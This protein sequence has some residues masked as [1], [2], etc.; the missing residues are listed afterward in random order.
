[1]ITNFDSF[2]FL[3]PIFFFFL[4]IRQP[5]RSTL[6]PYTT[7]FRST[8]PP[9]L[10]RGNPRHEPRRQ[11]HQPFQDARRRRQARAA[12]A[13]RGGLARHPR[14]DAGL[15]PAGG[16]HSHARRAAGL[17]GEAWQVRVLHRARGRGAALRPH[18]LRLA[19]RRGVHGALRGHRRRRLRRADGGA[20]RHP[21]E[22]AGPRARER[23]GH[24]VP[25]RHPDVL[26]H[27]VQD[28]RRH[29]RAPAR[30]PRRVPGRAH[31]DGEQGRVRPQGPVGPR[32]HDPQHRARRRGHPAAEDRDRHP[33]GL[34]VFRPRAVRPSRRRSA[35]EP[36][37]AIRRRD[38]RGAARRVRGLAR[39]QADRRQDDHERG[40]PG[41]P[42]PRAGLRR[43]RQDAG[44]QVRHADLPLHGSV[45]A[46]QLRQHPPEA[47]ARE[48]AVS[49]RAAAGAWA[50][51]AGDGASATRPYA[52]AAGAVAVAGV[53]TAILWPL[54]QPVGTPL[55][56]AAVAVSS[57]HGGL[58]PGL[59]A[60][61]LAALVADW[62][63]V[64]PFYE[65]NAGT[66]VRV[67]AFVM[68]ALLTASLYERA[69]R[70]QREA[71]ALARAREWL[72]RD[73]QAA[74]AAAETAS[75]AKD[76]FLATLSHE[77]RTPLNALVG[78]TWW[79][80]R[81][82]LP[83]ERRARALETLDR[84]AKA[85]AQLIEDLL[86]VSRIITGK[87]RLSVRT[88]DL[89]AVV[90]A[91]IAAVL[92]AAT[93]KSLELRVSVMTVGPMRGDP[94]RLQ[95]VVWNLLSNAI[96]FTPE[97]GTVT[98]RVLRDAEAATIVV[99]DSG[100]GIDPDV[101]PQIFER[102]MQGGGGRRSGGLGLGLSIARHIVELH[103]GTIQAASEGAGRGAAFTVTLPLAAFG[104]EA[105][106]AAAP[107]AEQPLARLDGLRVL[108]VDDD[109]AARE[110]C[111]L[112]LGSAGAVTTT[113]GSA[114]EAMA[115]LGREEPDVLVSD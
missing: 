56:F 75:R 102:F 32:R 53:Y 77:L 48:V 105:A 45:A 41:R 20:R 111:A 29:H 91:A 96:K 109:P 67:A 65:L 30:R 24:A 14:G 28:A 115:A 86:E 16:R 44:R 27:R 110:W 40:V 42:R 70:A 82:D 107:A 94:D 31:E 13:G 43:A 76:E 22:R 113:V 98:V 68:V 63:F 89:P 78:W 4:M 5:P 49:M 62:F 69:R 51:G 59:L 47:G 38:L 60:T 55:F 81:G 52:V 84:N 114:A 103:G 79:L 58:G 25:D 73:E 15:P 37:G 61:A 39:Q 72:L 17:V 26:R 46:V 106:V 11:A 101:L 10:D 19:A 83:P 1:M 23:G 93:A 57:W 71:E 9:E 90:D 2:V 3:P 88:L 74:R 66:L 80:K 50:A 112:T 108:V 36:F 104:E 85:V 35:P 8:A 6:F 12:G 99:S 34:D 21:R 100:Q 7:L 95:Q 97:K 64:P 87:T 18:R 33:E 54:L 92:P